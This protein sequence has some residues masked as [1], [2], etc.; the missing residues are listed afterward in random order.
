MIGEIFKTLGKSITKEAVAK[1]IA[2]GVI[3]I[4]I[5]VGSYYGTKAVIAQIN[6]R[7]VDKEIVRLTREQ[8]DAVM[9]MLEND[10]RA[11]KIREKELILAEM[12]LRKEMNK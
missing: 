4:G 10:A 2:K 5:G 12:A 6:K 3:E 7:L 11:K 9:K 8:E 1:V